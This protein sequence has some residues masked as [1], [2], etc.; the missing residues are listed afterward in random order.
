MEDS[1]DYMEIL[2]KEDGNIHEWTVEFLL[3]NK[4]KAVDMNE[5]PAILN[6]KL[7]TV[8]KG[9][10][11]LLTMIE[12]PEKLAV[13]TIVDIELALSMT[14]HTKNQHTEGDFV[15]Y[16]LNYGTGKNRVTL[17]ANYDDLNVLKPIFE[18]ILGI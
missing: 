10:Q 6:G 3:W 8:A 16:S 9:F 4:G 2:K 11:D 17:W 13:L 14:H 15:I 12:T 18:L 1:K 5:K 7:T